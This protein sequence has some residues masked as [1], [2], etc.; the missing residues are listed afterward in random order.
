[1]IVSLLRP[2]PLIEIVPGPWF[3]AFFWQPHPVQKKHLSWGQQ[4]G[5]AGA[6]VQPNLLETGQHVGK[7]VEN[8]FDANIGVVKKS[9]SICSCNLLDTGQH[10][11]KWNDNYYFIGSSWSQCKKKCWCFLNI[12]S[13]SPGIEQSNLGKRRSEEKEVEEKK[14]IQN[15]RSPFQNSFGRPIFF[16][17]ENRH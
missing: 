9:I 6:R 17:E 5:E 16:Y 3:C 7:W 4:I 10:V 8:H 14:P 1:M 11:R 12:S 2:W 13:C 15:R